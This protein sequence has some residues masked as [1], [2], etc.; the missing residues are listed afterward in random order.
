MRVYREQAA[1]PIAELDRKPCSKCKE[2]RPIEDFYVRKAK[3]KSGGYVKRPESWCKE[4]TKRIHK[5]RMAKKGREGIDLATLRKGYE[6]KENRERRLQRKREWGA[7]R[8]REE[9]RPVSKR[10]LK[11]H[12]REGVYLPTKPLSTF[13]RKEVDGRGFQAVSEAVGLSERRLSSILAC[14]YPN[15]TLQVVD[16][17]L[18]ALGVPHELPILYPEDQ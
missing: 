18:S 12:P 17:F 14:E 13:L 2:V 8:R 1:M 3:L 6:A 5:E 15:V 10:S 7:T 9:G 4:C 16:R 11:P